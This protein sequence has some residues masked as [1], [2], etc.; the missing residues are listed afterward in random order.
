MGS[1]GSKARGASI[2]SRHVMQLQVE[3]DD[4]QSFEEAR[5]MYCDNVVEGYL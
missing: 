1:Q 4:R 5:R 3:R 2:S